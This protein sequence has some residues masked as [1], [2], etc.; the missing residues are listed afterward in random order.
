MSIHIDLVNRALSDAEREVVDSAMI[1]MASKFRERD[2]FFNDPEM[3]KNYLRLRLGL[4][5]RELFI[6]LF[7]DSQHRLIVDETL[8]MGTIDAAGVYPRI[9]AQKALQYNAAAL[10][11]AHNHPSGVAEPSRADRSITE[12]LTGALALFDIR[13][14]DHFVVGYPDV[15]SF[16]ERGWL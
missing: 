10:V 2:Q 6:T 3:V 8:F 9:V 14:L 16:A 1:I 15:I 12:R 4:E 5:E 13:L 7:L 11:L